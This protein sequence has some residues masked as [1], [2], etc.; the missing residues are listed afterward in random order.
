MTYRTEDGIYVRV[1]E[2]KAEPGTYTAEAKLRPFRSAE[3]HSDLI[4]DI[5]GDLWF[6]FS[7]RPDHAINTLLTEV[8]AHLARADE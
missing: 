2:S 8:R 5:Y 4:H 3:G 6:T 7:D 1:Y